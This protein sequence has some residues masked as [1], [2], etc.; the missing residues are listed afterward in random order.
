MSENETGTNG[1]GTGSNG[2]APQFAL[3]K[4][5]IKDFSFEVP[6]A[7]S[8][9]SEN[10]DGLEFQLNLKNYHAALGGDLYEVVLH[11]TV[12]ALLGQTSVFLIELAQSG[13]FQIK[14]YS[15]DDLKALAG[16]YCPATLFPY[17]REAISAAVSR[18]GFPP[19]TLQPVNFDAIYARA[20]EA[21]SKG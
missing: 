1:N 4:I 15:G 19:L 2:D 7:P 16:T 18:G 14:G 3:Q 6:G 21:A 11:V 20:S 12:H 9:Y 10:L 5:F 17:A 8:V 13:I